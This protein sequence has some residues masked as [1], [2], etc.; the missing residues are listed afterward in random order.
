MSQLMVQELYSVTEISSLLVSF[1][2]GPSLEH[3]NCR[4]S[5]RHRLQLQIPAHLRRFLQPTQGPPYASA[6][7]PPAIKSEAP[8]QQSSSILVPN[9]SHQ[10]W[11]PVINDF[12]LEAKPG[13]EPY[14]ASE[15]VPTCA[16]ASHRVKGTNQRPRVKSPYN[17]AIEMSMP[18]GDSRPRALIQVPSPFH[19]AIANAQPCDNC[20]HG[21]YTCLFDI[22][23]DR[24]KTSSGRPTASCVPCR[25][26]GRKCVDGISSD[27][28]KKIA[29]EWNRSDPDGLGRYHSLKAGTVDDSEHWVVEARALGEKYP[30]EKG[31]TVPVKRKAGDQLEGSRHKRRMTAGDRSWVEESSNGEDSG[32]SHSQP[33]SMRNRPK[34]LS[35]A[36]QHTLVAP[37]SS[38]MFH[39]FPAALAARTT[40]GDT[41]PNNHNAK[42]NVK[43]SFHKGDFRASALMLLPY[44]TTE[45]CELCKSEGIECR[46]DISPKRKTLTNNSCAHCKKV[47]RACQP[48]IPQQ[49]VE[50]WKE[51]WKVED[52][53]SFERL[54]AID[55]GTVPVHQPWYLDALKWGEIYPLVKD[56]RS[57]K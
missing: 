53:I 9:S 57:R 30:V 11:H 52:S 38:S 37:D 8:S 17:W 34:R 6:P 43:L 33:S 36:S 21:D 44:D 46:V 7:A 23:P 35:N 49:V 14:H 13:T 41:S 25:A 20:R 56:A 12:Q 39:I 2:L 50:G 1:L 40:K 48:S 32:G 42:W 27:L 3:T 16:V 45:P 26:R 29:D 31:Y 18:E 24:V 22:S 28:V 5:G 47:H 51:A 54:M 15:N 55:K 19:P 4:N 10:I